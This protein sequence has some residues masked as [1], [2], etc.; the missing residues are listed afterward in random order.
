MLKLVQSDRF[1]LST[2]TTLPKISE[3]KNQRTWLDGNLPDLRTLNRELRSPATEEVLAATNHEEAIEIA[4]RHL[5]L[6]GATVPSVGIDTPY[7]EVLIQR[8][9][10]YHIVEK[11][12]DARE[13]YVKM[14][15][16]T[17]TGPFEIWRVAFTDNTHRL[18]Y[19]GVYES[20]R[21]MLVSVRMIDGQQMWNFMH[22]DAK[23]LNKHRHGELLYQRYTLL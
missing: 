21:Q 18:A 14:A 7:G 12:I 2:D 13:R 16:D 22:C 9:S 8:A 23:G 1:P 3:Q 6:G 20:K 15:L 4:A 11:R 5:G 19:I 17:L 10:L